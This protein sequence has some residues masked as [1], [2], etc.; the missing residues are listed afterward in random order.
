M[1]ELETKIGF[2]PKKQKAIIKVLGVGGGGSNAVNNMFKQG[3]EGVDFVVCNTDLQALQR[4]PV[5][6][7]V[8]LGSSGLGAG[9]DPEVARIAAED[10][11]NKIKEVVD[12]ETEMLFITAGMGGGTGTGAAPVIARYA[13]E[14]K[15]LS[16]G[17]VTLPFRFEGR[18]KRQRAEL[19]IEELRKY[20]DALLV[21]SNDKLSDI[22]GNLSLSNA[23]EHVDSVL[24]K[25]AK[26]IAEL[27]TVHGYVNVDFQDVRTVMRDSGKAIMGSAVADGEDRAIKAIENAMVSPL[28]NDNDITGAKY[29]LLYITTSEEKDITL[30]E[31]MKV[32]DYIN[33]KCGKEAEV[34]WGRGFDEAM[35]NKV[36]ITIIATGF[37][38]SETTKSKTLP[39]ENKK[40]HRLDENI[41]KTKV[42]RVTEKPIDDT[43]PADTVL[44][45]EK[46]TPTTK[47]NLKMKKKSK[48]E[49]KSL[50]DDPPTDIVTGFK[51][52]AGNN[53]VH[54]L[55]EEN[56][57]PEN[58][59]NKLK[60]YF[61]EEE[62][63]DFEQKSKRRISELIK[64][65]KLKKKSL[66]ELE[67]EPAYIRRKVQLSE[68][69]YSS[70]ENT[71]KLSLGKDSNNNIILKS[72]NTYL[73]DSID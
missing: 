15:L 57:I 43:Q 63:N 42:K 13:R 69:K 12:E 72:D 14:L 46:K 18:R 73:H 6:V 64:L 33:E 30:D 71:S 48:E 3:I 35:S 8:Q 1:D 2:K 60:I 54:Q 20:V 67:N 40:V 7:K 10:S 51:P 59:K 19:G 53:I 23:F 68:P 58:S 66:T 44:L 21:I 32:T 5:P 50:F 4:S 25:A 24:T 41:E 31:V 34:I 52:S 61:D 47:E 56:D 36:G 28:L 11:L 26:G 65:S 49:E 29:I 62:K 45:S 16:V 70:D 38:N 27:I 22:Y 37:S 39:K 17:I 55:E 9:A